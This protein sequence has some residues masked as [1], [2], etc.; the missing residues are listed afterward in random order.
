MSRTS[1][2][3]QFRCDTHHPPVHNVSV[4]MPEVESSIE[5]RELYFPLIRPSSLTEVE[6]YSGLPCLPPVKPESLNRCH[7]VAAGVSPGGGGMLISILLTCPSVS[8]DLPNSEVLPTTR[9]LNWSLWMY[10][11]AT[12]ATSGWFTLSIPAR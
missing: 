9:I 12:R 8:R 4:R 6:P 3:A 7:F 5:T 1:V 2:K 10:L 11:V